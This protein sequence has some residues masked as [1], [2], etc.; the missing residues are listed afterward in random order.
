[1]E[2]EVRMKKEISLALLLG[3][4]LMTPPLLAQQ[5]QRPA[6]GGPDLVA[7]LKA[8]PGC[9]GVETA[10]TATGKQVIFAWFENKKA[11]LDWYYS[12]MHQ[13]LMAQFFPGATPRAPMPDV[14]DNGQPILAIAS[15]TMAD[16]PVSG[17]TS[18]PI[19]QIAIELYQPLPGGIALG[20]RFSPTALKVPGLT[21][22]PL[23]V[24][25]K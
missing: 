14:V 24:S 13:Q 6:P 16:K 10:R 18:L 3:S 7:A 19:S 11:L 8:V 5:S 23:P 17:V 2:L 20:G 15:V 22:I 9:L 12:P 1:M 4:L 25:A 21:D